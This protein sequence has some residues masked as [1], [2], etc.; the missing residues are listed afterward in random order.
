MIHVGDITAE[1][2]IEQPQDVLKVGQTVKAVVL[3]TDREKRRIRLGMKQLQPTSTDEYIA[4]HKSGD[5]V[6]GRVLKVGKAEAEVELGEGLK[7][8]CPLPKDARKPKEQAGPASA[9]VSSL[10]AM[11]AAKWKQG[12]SLNSESLGEP[13]RAGQVRSFRIAGLDPAQKRIELEFV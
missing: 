4:E 6:T 11:L 9:D 2:R 10:S 7:A 8:S 13:V 1:K 3:E 5:V 12:K